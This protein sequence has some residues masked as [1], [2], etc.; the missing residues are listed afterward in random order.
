MKQPHFIKYAK[1]QSPAA[2]ADSDESAEASGDS[3]EVVIRADMI[4][5]G[6]S[7]PRRLRVVCFENP[8]MGLGRFAI[9]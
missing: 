6:S 3:G 4:F 5:L 7:Y 1:R 9:R 2:Q 8:N